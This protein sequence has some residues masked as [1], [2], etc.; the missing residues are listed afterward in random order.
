MINKLSL[1]REIYRAFG[2]PRTD[3]QK[4]AGVPAAKLWDIVLAS[5]LREVQV[6]SHNPI[7]AGAL[8]RLRQ[9]GFEDPFEITP[10]IIAQATKVIAKIQAKPR[11]TKALWLFRS[12]IPSRSHFN[13]EGVT[14]FGLREAEGGLSIPYND[15]SDLPLRKEFGNLL[16]KEMLSFPRT[17]L[18]AVCLEYSFLLTAMLRSVGIKAQVKAAD[19]HAYVIISI[20]AKRFKADAVELKF[21]PTTERPSPDRI[22]AA[23]HYC[24][25]ADAFALVGKYQEA[26]FCYDR[27]L[28]LK[29]DSPDFWYCKGS[30]LKE[31]KRF[32]EADRCFE[33]AEQINRSQV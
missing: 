31:L 17:E 1:N 19:F 27:A 12:V 22:S 15:N 25:K 16:P 24:F 26:L 21:E 10:E 32:D 6:G 30:V 23:M 9:A 29:P 33:R 4:L 14:Y 7:T 2:G 13:F 3:R 28:E 18:F 8:A 5:R 11:L 20:G